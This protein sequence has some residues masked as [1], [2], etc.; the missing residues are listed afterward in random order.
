MAIIFGSDPKDEGSNPSASANSC[1]EQESPR[2]GAFLMAQDM[3]QG[4]LLLS[5]SSTWS[6]QLRTSPLQPSR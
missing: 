4:S 6:R 1:K 5:A 2:N 3:R